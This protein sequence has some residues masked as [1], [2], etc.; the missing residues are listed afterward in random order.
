MGDIEG[1]LTQ[2]GIAFRRFDHAPVF[3]CAEAAAL[4]PHVPGTHTKNL[5]LRDAKG[6]RHFLV[7]VG[8]E[9]NV[10]LKALR[11]VLDADKLSFASPE[12]LKKY[13]GVDP[14]AASVLGLIADTEHAVEV[15]FDPA[16]WKAPALQCHPL[17][18]TATLVIAHEGIEKFLEATGHTP[19]IEEVPERMATL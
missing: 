8:Y 12:R 1:F 13:L 11:K 5:F 14:G 6:K 10:D 4:L 7:V 2:N 15:L 9:K 17:V 19:H 16:I 18:N 3:T